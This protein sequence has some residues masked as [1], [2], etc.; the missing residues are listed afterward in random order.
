[1]EKTVFRPED[2]PP[3]KRPRPKPKSLLV[4]LFRIKRV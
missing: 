3:Q 1:M 2:L 4:G